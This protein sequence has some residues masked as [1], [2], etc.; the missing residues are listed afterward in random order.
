MDCFFCH[1]SVASSDRFCS[2][3]GARLAAEDVNTNSPAVADVLFDHRPFEM[4]VAV[5]P[6]MICVL[7]VVER[8]Y[9]Y[10]NEAM[11]RFLGY[12]CE[13]LVAADGVRLVVGRVHP[14]DLHRTIAGHNELLRLSE[15]ANP[16]ERRVEE[17]EYRLQDSQ[18][19]W[20]WVHSWVTVFAR[21]SDG[22]VSQILGIAHEITERKQA[23]YTLLLNERRFRLAL[24]VASMLSWDWTIGTNEVAFSQ[25]YG[26]YYGF[27]HTGTIVPNDET[28]LQPIH[29]DDRGPLMGAFHDS[30]QTGRDFQIEFRGPLRSGEQSWYHTLG[31]IVETRDGQPQRMIGVTL[32]ITPRKQAEEALGRKN[33]ELERLLKERA[34]ELLSVIEDLKRLIAEREAIEKTLRLAQFSIDRAA[35]EVFWIGPHAEI[36]YVNDAA[37]RILG[38]SR[39]E[40]LGKEV[41]SVD[42]NFPAEAWP[43]HWADLKRQGSLSFESYQRTKDG[44]LI[45]TEMTANYIAYDGH[46]YNC[47]TVRDITARKRAERRL[48]ESEERFRQITAAIQD[49][50]WV[51]D[52]ETATN[53]YISPAYEQIWGRSCQS[54]IEDA[55]SFFD[56]IHPEDR[57]RVYA[58]LVAKIEKRPFE[59]DYRIIRPDGTIRWIHDRGFPVPATAM[60]E[61][62]YVGV[63]QDITERKQAELANA[64][65]LA[66]LEG[67]PDFVGS[68]DAKTG[69]IQ[70]I[71]HA[72]RELVG[73]TGEDDLTGHKLSEFHPEW[74]NRLLREVILPTAVREGVWTGECAFLHRDGREIPVM[75]VLLAYTSPSGEVDRFST[76]SRDI[77]DRKQSEEKLRQSEA[78]LAEAQQL[79]HVGSWNLDFADNTLVWSDEHYR[80]CG[81]NPQEEAIPFEHGMSYVHPDDRAMTREIVGR[82]IRDHQPYECCVR[83][84]HRDGT[85]RFAQSR[86]QAVYDAGGNPV[87]M[88]GT[89]Q[90]ITDRKRVEESLRESEQRNRTIVRTAMDGFW[91]IDVRGRLLEVNEAYCRM[92]G[93]SEQELLAMSVPDLEAVETASEAATHIERI[94]AH[95]TERFESRHRRKDG[96]SYPIEVSAQYRP[97]QGGQLFT[98]LRD[99]TER[100]QAESQVRELSDALSHSKR[101]ATL[102]EIAT[103]LAH[104]LNQPLG[105]LHLDATTAMSLAG[106]LE[107][108][109]LSDCLQRISDQSFRA[110][111]IIRRMRS[112]IRRGSSHKMPNDTNRLVR[113]VLLLLGNDLRENA[114]TVELT[115]AE[116]LPP[117]MVDG[118][119]IQQ[120]LVNLIRNAGEAMAQNVD[121]AR[122]LS[123]R[124]ETFEG[125][126]RVSVSDTGCGLDPAVTGKL[127][128]PFQTTKP[129]GLGLGLSICRTLVEAHNGHI[130][131]R[132]NPGR[133]T[134]F[135]FSVPVAP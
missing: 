57:D 105:A 20:R 49:V 1:A 42:P 27:P 46:E 61:P 58:D 80:I 121:A 130:E 51:A 65:L 86:G 48:R 114:V 28:I 134:T 123:L 85:V 68:A 29:P 74:A 26:A 52:D 115:L 21:T 109:G 63:A 33:E 96:T 132:P 133:G 35:D 117:A 95:G 100:K 44:R 53:H 13:Q 107:T 40:L 87:R 97:E 118:I 75:M 103:G 120:V 30:V 45:D 71:N 69:Q 76:I 8:R 66:I 19:R 79:A 15:G 72:G 14:E 83:L 127:F 135:S 11:V 60:T 22:R 131:V 56:A 50:F 67:T 102:G 24:D 16:D 5:F 77:T 39:E 129:T 104:E 78:L 18:G 54:L 81:L 93:Y 89:L 98:F 82:A 91:R 32:D 64:R 2:R 4:V 31:R 36:L 126:V 122:V 34:A 7:D 43:A 17:F 110:G 62:C 41:S 10:V 108:P 38:Y 9:S 55:R 84:R 128:F 3:C 59:H 113:E 119:Q 47:A 92:S 88:F 37:C 125:E 111:E 25:D 23:E 90:D 124:T 12:P 73:L 94:I 101:V 6:N 70:Y 112:F 116:R 99:I 106:G